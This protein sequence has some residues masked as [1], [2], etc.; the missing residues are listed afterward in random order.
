M[1]QMP[2]EIFLLLLDRGMRQPATTLPSRIMA[3]SKGVDKIYFKFADNK[4]AN[5]ER[6]LT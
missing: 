2:P 6:L 5:N 4:L 3:I 1:R